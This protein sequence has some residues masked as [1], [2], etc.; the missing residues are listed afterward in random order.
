M[1]VLFL[2]NNLGGGGA[3]RVLVNLVNHMVDDGCD[4]TLRVLSN[5]GSNRQFLSSKVKY[6]YIFKNNFRGM[7]Y[8]HLLPR[9][10]VYSK[11][12]HGCFDVIVVYLHGVLTKIVSYAPKEQ[13][14]VA[15]LHAN[16]EKSPFMKSFKSKEA[17]QKCFSRYSRIISVS[18]DVQNSFIKASG[19]DDNR[20]KVLYNTF[21]VKSILIK[22]KEPV[23]ITEHDYNIC[24]VG[25]LESVKGYLR[26]VSL[27]KTLC[28]EN[29]DVHLAIVGEGI[30]RPELENM[31]KSNQMSNNVTLVGF[32]SNPYK[33]I[34]NSDL[35]VCSSYTEGF[36]SVVAE[37]L[38]LGVPV[39]TTDCP[40]MREM[41]GDNEYGIITENSDEGLYAGLKRLL[42]DPELL[43]HYTQK[44][45]ER[46]GFFSPKQTVGAVERM[47]EEVINE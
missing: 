39:I 17:V 20:L 14:T 23:E 35:F 27:M 31:I 10:W 25:K 32:D 1:K 43:K 13:K 40:G 22:S 38:I 34:A 16:M 30:Q 44:A 8:L 46:S 19:I 5:T 41:L 6:E 29:M 33:Y 28:D 47:L 24:S 4:I 7:N 37:S 11:V 21:D 26:L 18:Q 15:Y 9:H 2:T 42:S 45:K 3:E 36:S 12:T